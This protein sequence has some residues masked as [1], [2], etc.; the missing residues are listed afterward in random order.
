MKE[1][2]TKTFIHFEG[3]KIFVFSGQLPSFSVLDLLLLSCECHRDP[4]SHLEMMIT[5][6]R[7][8]PV[9]SFPELP[10]SSTILYPPKRVRKSN[11]DAKTD[12][13]NYHTKKSKESGH[14]KFLD[15]K[16]TATLTLV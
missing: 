14:C 12:C 2:A 10:L 16:L 9:P 7:K 5:S 3:H 8:L 6:G 4:S 15:I 11:I 1:Y 13:E